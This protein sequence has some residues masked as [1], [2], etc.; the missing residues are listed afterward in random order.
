LVGEKKNKRQIPN[1]FANSVHFGGFVLF[2]QI[3]DLPAK[4]ANNII[5]AA[6]LEHIFKKFS[7]SSR[8][9]ALLLRAKTQ[10]L[11]IFLRS[12]F[13]NCIQSLTDAIFKRLC[14]K[15]QQPSKI[16]HITVTFGID[17]FISIIS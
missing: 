5:I 9:F 1:L 12:A 13:S 7:L 11:L 16:S 15:G 17:S 4:N 8:L 14:P 10:N 6:L 3:R 2:C